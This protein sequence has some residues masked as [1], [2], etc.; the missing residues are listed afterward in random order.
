MRTASLLLTLL[1]AGLAGCASIPSGG[2]AIREIHLFGVP[3]AINFDQKP[4]PD[5]FAFRI[6]ASDGRAPKGVA[7]TNGKLEILLFDGAPSDAERGTTPPLRVWTYDPKKLR[8]VA[9]RSSIGWG[10]R[11]ALQWDDAR[12][13]GDRFAVVARYVAPSGAVVSSS[14]GVISMTIH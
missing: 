5:G 8:E 11:F 12:P 6:Y 4:G 9:G 14:P 13:T 3:V 1:A 7:I 10:Y 2:S